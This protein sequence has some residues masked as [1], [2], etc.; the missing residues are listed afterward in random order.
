MTFL[1]ITLF[2]FLFLSKTSMNNEYT[3]VYDEASVVQNI[4]C[5]IAQK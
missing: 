1:K 2:Y 5:V 3:F 4:M